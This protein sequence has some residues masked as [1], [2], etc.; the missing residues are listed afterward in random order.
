MKTNI[1]DIRRFLLLFYIVDKEFIRNINVV[2]NE[3]NITLLN[4]LILL[5]IDE[6]EIIYLKDICD[7]LFLDTGTLTPV[8]KR[9]EQ[10]GLIYRVRSLKDERK[11]EIHPTEHGRELRVILSKVIEETI[12]NLNIDITEK[13]DYV[14]SLKE[15]SENFVGP[16]K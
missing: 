16:I 4:Y 10:K 11:L 15:L 13:S 6:E 3:Y 12:D 5:S 14:K 1:I 7:K 8:T 2:L 9:L